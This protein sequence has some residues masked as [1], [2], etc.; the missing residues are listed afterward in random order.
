[1]NK[2]YKTHNIADISN[3]L[4]GQTCTISGWA[5]KIRDLGGVI[6]LSLRDRSGIVQV[7]FDSEKNASLHKQAFVIRSEWVV[8]IKGLVQ[9]RDETNINKNIPNG[10][11]E[12]EVQELQILNKAKTPAISIAEDKEAEEIT[13]L[14]YRYLDLR[15]PEKQKY[16]LIRNKV[17]NSIRGYLDKQGFIDVETPFLTKSTPEGARDFLVPSRLQAKHFYALPQSPQLFKQLLMISG[18]EKYYQIVRCFRDEDLRADRQP[19]FTQVDLEASFVEPKDIINVTNG[20]IKAA[21]NTIGYDL[22]DIPTITYQ[23]AMDLYGSDAPDLRFDLP[24]TDI[25]KKCAKLEFKI[26]KDVYDQGGMIKGI[27]VPNGADILSRKKVDDL[28]EEV[29]MFDIKGILAIH[30]RSKEEIASPL[31]KFL[32]EIELNEWIQEFQAETGDSILFIAHQNPKMVNAALSKIRSLIANLTGIEKK[33]FAAC[34]VIDFP[35]FETGSDGNIT[36]S[37]HPF[38]APM[39]EDIPLLDSEPEKVRSKAYDIVINGTEIG[40]GSIRIHDQ[41]LQNK[42]FHLL[43][44]NENEIKDK[45]GFFIEALQYGTPPHGGLAIGLDRLAMILTGAKSIR[46]VIAFPKTTNAQCPLTNAPSI[47]NDEQLKELGIKNI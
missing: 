29:R 12:I 19:E 4:I 13:R 15:K 41:K 17:Q 33:Q 5:H 10:D 30:L 6:F 2:K 43:G 25:T 36:P 20:T 24:L 28:T 32:S 42:M 21:F 34:W 31:T 11:I 8:T 22:S 40:G 16:L 44:M 7:T 35:L 45:F 23:D 1:M 14:K 9:K 47:V 38:T 39:D 46:D 27:R 26:F 37:H 3:K 18:L